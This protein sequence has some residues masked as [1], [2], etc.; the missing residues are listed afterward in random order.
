MTNV[1]I[2]HS[3]LGNSHNHWYKWLQHN[4]ELEGYDVQLFHL[5]E[6]K[7]DNIDNWIFELNQQI[8]LLSKDT[9]FVTHGY[10]SLATLKYIEGLSIYEPFEGFF[11][12]A[13]FKEDAKKIDDSIKVGEFNVDYDLIKTK[14]N[15]FYGLAS[16]DDS[17]VSYLE[18]QNLIDELGGKTKIVNEGGH[19]L[20]EEG[21]V[22]FT[23]LQE[24][25]QH[26]MTK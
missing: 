12:I 18:T 23:E 20:E 14:V 13:G 19:F 25:M 10:G 4:L 8:E 6:S 9:Y 2:V 1:I 5:D 22:S 21:F 7:N 15:H 26:Y 24:K 17:Y 3:Q 16:K 11:S